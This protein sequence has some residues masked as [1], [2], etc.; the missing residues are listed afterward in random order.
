MLPLKQ[1]WKREYS[2]LRIAF[3]FDQAHEKWHLYVPKPN[4]NKYQRRCK[5]WDI[6]HGKNATSK[7][8]AISKRMTEFVKNNQTFSRAIV[9]HFFQVVKAWGC[10]DE[11]LKYCDYPCVPSVRGVPIERPFKIDEI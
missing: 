3:Y 9:G 1:E 4:V 5:A 6:V 2:H 8:E 7:L 11:A 10:C